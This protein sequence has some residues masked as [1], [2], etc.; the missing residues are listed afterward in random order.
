MDQGP[1]IK[2]R[3]KTKKDEPQDEKEIPM[4]KT[5]TNGKIQIDIM[6]TN[7]NIAEPEYIFDPKT[8][9]ESPK[10]GKDNVTGVKRRRMSYIAASETRRSSRYEESDEQESDDESPEGKQIRLVG[11]RFN[12]GSEED[13][14]TLFQRESLAHINKLQKFEDAA[15]ARKLQN[16]ESEE[17]LETH[18]KI[19]SVTPDLQRQHR[20]DE[21]AKTAKAKK[22]V[23]KEVAET[24]AKIAKLKVEEQYE[25]EVVAEAVGKLDMKIDSGE[26]SNI[27]RV[28]NLL[29]KASLEY[30]AH[31]EDLELEI[32]DY[33]KSPEES[34]D[35]DSDI[36]KNYHGELEFPRAVCEQRQL[37]KKLDKT[38]PE[39]INQLRA[40]GECV[41]QKRTDEMEILIRQ[42]E[43]EAR[44]LR[45]KKLEQ[46]IQIAKD[47]LK[48]EIQNARMIKN[49]KAE[50]MVA[51]KAFDCEE[52]AEKEIEGYEQE[53]EESVFAVARRYNDLVSKYRVAKSINETEDA[54]TAEAGDYIKYFNTVK[55]GEAKAKDEASRNNQERILLK[56]KLELAKEHEKAAEE[57]AKKHE[58]AAEESYDSLLKTINGDDLYIPS[59][60]EKIVEEADEYN[61]DENEEAKSSS[62]GIPSLYEYDSD[63]DSMKDQKTCYSDDEPDS[64]DDEE[65]LDIYTITPRRCCSEGARRLVIIADASWPLDEPNAIVPKLAVVDQ[66]HDIDPRLTEELLSQP[67]HWEVNKNSMGVW[68]GAQKNKN[69]RRIENLNATIRIYLENE[70]TGLKSKSMWQLKVE[71]CKK[72]DDEN[73]D[74]CWCSK[75]KLEWIDGH[76]AGWLE[77]ANTPN[78]EPYFSDD[79]V[80]V[81]KESEDETVVGIV[82]NE[83]TKPITVKSM[84]H[85]Y[86]YEDIA[87]PKTMLRTK[88]ENYEGKPVYNEETGKFENLKYPELVSTRMGGTR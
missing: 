31:V 39:I 77:G 13:I 35:S 26:K 15:N 8:T 10:L 20:L 74:C 58:K 2:V 40:A 21:E 25:P 45:F 47:K 56:M 84:G 22:E 67:S 3:V 38:K 49:L 68:I 86:R 23:L 87:W 33:T 16:I 54:S 60:S 69:I 30:K 62:Q 52:E 63:N 51:A 81:I 5:P 46:D 1:S 44:A 61:S 71:T 7:M 28:M 11:L 12:P 79:D 73:N 19:N 59:D 36:E 65:S 72:Q 9:G 24:A 88:P 64:S 57:L 66:Y 85:N 82:D 18:M 70:K 48:Q 14:G 29:A 41:K 27:N 32:N 6:F 83:K 50:G 42:A 4:L 76:P 75:E 34:E 78:M 17:K 53:A 80:V 55:Y 37:W 43:E